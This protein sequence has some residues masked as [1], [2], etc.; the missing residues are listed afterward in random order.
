MEDEN[1]VDL[2]VRIVK[3]STIKVVGEDVWNRL[4]RNQKHKLIM[5]VCEDEIMQAEE[6]AENGNHK[7]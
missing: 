2:L 6:R 7:D 5:R 4:D 3:E 1:I